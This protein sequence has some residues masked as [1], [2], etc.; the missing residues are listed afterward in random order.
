MRTRDNGSDG[1][2]GRMEMV[3]VGGG[4]G[5]VAGMTHTSVR[6]RAS[7]WGHGEDIQEKTGKW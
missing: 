4:S 1:G 5:P 3:D 7:R 6:S 2:G